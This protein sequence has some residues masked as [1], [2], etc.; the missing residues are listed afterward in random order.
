MY[1]LKPIYYINGI[2]KV[3]TLLIASDVKFIEINL[4]IIQ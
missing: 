2:R 3:G 4:G 1:S